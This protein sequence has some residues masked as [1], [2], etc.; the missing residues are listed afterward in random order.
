MEGRLATLRQSGVSIVP[1]ALA[2]GQLADGFLAALQQLNVPAAAQER[3]MEIYGDRGV[4]SLIAFYRGVNELLRDFGVQSRYQVTQLKSCHAPREGLPRLPQVPVSAPQA[5]E[6]LPLTDWRPGTIRDL[7]VRQFVLAPAI[8]FAGLDH[9]LYAMRVES[10]M[11]DALRDARISA[12]VRQELNRVL[13]TL[14]MH[15]LPAPEEFARPDSTVRLFIRQLMLLGY[16]DQD[17]PLREFDMLQTMVARI[18]AENG[19]DLDTFHSG[20]EALYTLARREVRR[21]LLQRTLGDIGDDAE[22]GPLKIRTLAE[23]ARRQVANDLREHA[24]GMNLAPEAQEFVLRLLGPWMMVRYQR[25]GRDSRAW[26]EARTFAALFFDALRPA[27]EP[28]DHERK[29]AVRRQVLTQARLRTGRAQQQAPG[30]QELLA[31]L[32]RTFIRLDT[33]NGPE[34]ERHATSTAFLRTLPVVSPV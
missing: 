31:W 13:A 10:I 6:S 1:G 4:E 2:P 17:A 14:V 21:L 16:R 20:A 3:L 30:A 8:A 28:K 22:A 29:R 26:T 25:Y 18:V 34:P 12:R 9:N 5:V 23:E 11:L 33:R 27:A 24:L 15:C 32:E 19:Q 7:L